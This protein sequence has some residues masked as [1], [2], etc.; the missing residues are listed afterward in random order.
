[1]YEGANGAIAEA[2]AVDRGFMLNYV[3][4]STN[5]GINMG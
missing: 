1:M 5:C 4:D 3:M 2:K